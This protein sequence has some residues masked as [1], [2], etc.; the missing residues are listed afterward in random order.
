MGRTTLKNFELG[1]GGGLIFAWDNFFGPG[2]WASVVASDLTHSKF[3]V[4]LSPILNLITS[5]IPMLHICGFQLVDLFQ[6]NPSC[7][8]FYLH[9]CMIRRLGAKAEAI[10]SVSAWE[11]PTYQS[12]ASEHVQQ[13]LT[14]MH[15]DAH[16]LHAHPIES[17]GRACPSNSNAYLFEERR[18]WPMVTLRTREQRQDIKGHDSQRER[19]PPT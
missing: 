7:R 4:Y 11:M 18:N 9:A 1:G 13:A 17:N 10:A 14:D 2:S 5:A 8:V 16:R 3:A 6:S 19:A 12:S 15:L